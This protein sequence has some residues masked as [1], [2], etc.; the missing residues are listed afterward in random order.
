MASSRP[1]QFVITSDRDF[2][3]A[4]ADP[5]G[6]GVRYLLV[7]APELGSGYEDALQAS[8]I[9]HSPVPVASWRA[10]TALVSVYRRARSTSKGQREDRT[11]R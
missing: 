3:G 4:V 11:L 1:T 2:S 6:D 7:P 10:A 5:A 9:L 8:R